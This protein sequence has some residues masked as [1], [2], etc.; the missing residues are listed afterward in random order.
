LGRKRKV[1]EEVEII[2]MAEKG[3]AVGRTPEGQILMVSGAVPGDVV[4]VECRKKKKSVWWG[5]PRHFREKSPHRQ[6]PFCDHFE[7][8]GGCQWQHFSYEAQLTYKEKKVRDNLQRIGDLKDFEFLPILGAE[9]TRHYRNKM[10]YSFSAKRWITQEEIDEGGD[11]ENEGGLGFYRS[12][13]FE[14]VTDLDH[15]HLQPEPGNEIRNFVK[16]KA[17]ELGLSFYDNREHVGFLR[18]LLIRTTTTGQTMIVLAVGEPD[19]EKIDALL[20][21]LKETFPDL[22]SIYYTVNQKKNNFLYDLDM[23]HWHGEKQ[24]EERLGHLSFKIRPKSFFQTNTLQAR[25]LYDRVVDFAD[26]QGTE[27]VYDLYCGTGSIG[28]Y[29]ARN[30][31]SVVGI[32]EV[33]QAVL[34][35]RQNASDNGIEHAQFHLGRV[36]EVLTDAFQ[37]AHGVPDLLVTDPPRAGMHPD[38]VDILLQLKAPRMVYVSCNPATQA[39]DLAALSQAYRLVKIQ[40]VDMFPHTSHIESVA[41]LELKE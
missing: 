11:I 34:D 39:R 4:D 21:A 18:Q 38:V 17:L 26:L 29:L 27:N 23:H 9:Q 16:K 8:C 6:E 2:D 35:A 24:I 12:G 15:C 28:L 22:D 14:K 5:Q 30:C 41:L 3:Y 32:E 10:E 40:P 33:G 36:R 19:R 31:K 13:S 20:G 25:R 7:N 1:F 37:S